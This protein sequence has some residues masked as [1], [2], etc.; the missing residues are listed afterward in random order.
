L[1]GGDYGHQFNDRE[2][3]SARRPR[4]QSPPDKFFRRGSNPLPAQGVPVV[5]IFSK[6]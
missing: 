4:Y 2:N 6:T 3:G 1:A 5:H